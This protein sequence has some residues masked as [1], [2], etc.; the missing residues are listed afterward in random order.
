MEQLQSGVL[1]VLA[2]EDAREVFEAAR[3]DTVAESV[4]GL[5]SRL[6]GSDRVANVGTGW[7]LLHAALVGTGGDS[8]EVCFSLGQCLLGGRALGSEKTVAMFVR[9][10]L[11]LHVVR[12]LE[13]LEQDLFLSSWQQVL[14]EQTP[15]LSNNAAERNPWQRIEQIRGIYQHA[16]ERRE[17]ML[18]IVV[19]QD[20]G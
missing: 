11:V 14:A 9:P 20:P 7:A 17:A 1:L 6:E 16:G 3:T 5:L 8:E 18:F 2:R 13:A 12:E 4:V 19:S 15:E 10:D